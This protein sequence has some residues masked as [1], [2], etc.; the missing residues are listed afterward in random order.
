MWAKGSEIRRAGRRIREPEARERGCEAR[1][2]VTS[3]KMVR[4]LE[5]HLYVL[6]GN[7]ADISSWREKEI[8]L[9]ERHKWRDIVQGAQ[10][11]A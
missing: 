4:I 2:V 10:R 6:A 9:E 3:S 7:R 1:V 8:V 5:F 11:A